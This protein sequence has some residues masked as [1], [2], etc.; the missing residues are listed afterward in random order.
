MGLKKGQTNNPKGRMKGK[1][2]RLTSSLRDKIQMIV[3]NRIDNIDSDLEGLEPKDRIVILERLIQYII[4]KQ[5]AIT[6]EAQIQAEYASLEVLLSNA[7]EEAIEA[8][9]ERLIKLNQLN[10]QEN[11]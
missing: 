9:T 7:P 11:E 2:N 5:Q 4:P 10:K 6:V 3:N 1:P 8:I